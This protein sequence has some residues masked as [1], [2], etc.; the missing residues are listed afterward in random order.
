M[1]GDKEIEIGIPVNQ[2]TDRLNTNIASAQLGF[3]DYVIKP[4][5]EV[6]SQ[7]LSSVKIHLDSLIQ[8]REKWAELQDE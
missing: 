7:Y 6:W 3:I 2:M 5:F 4:T 8:N 1:Q